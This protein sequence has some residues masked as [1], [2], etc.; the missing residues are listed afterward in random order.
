MVQ[1]SELHAVNENH[2]TILR[3]EHNQGPQGFVSEFQLIR[4][5][6]VIPPLFSTN[7]FIRFLPVKMILS[8]VF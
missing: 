4:R 2:L 8:L 6:A 1:S 7:V 5:Q 3:N